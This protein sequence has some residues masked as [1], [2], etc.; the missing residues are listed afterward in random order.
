MLMWLGGE[1]V[2]AR[3]E[4]LREGRGGGVC[5]EAR[6]GRVISGYERGDLYVSL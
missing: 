3:E 1:E 2:V 4:A 6:V 5:R